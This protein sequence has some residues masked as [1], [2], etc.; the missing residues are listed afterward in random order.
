MTVPPR[1]LLKISNSVHVF[2]Y[3]TTGGRVWN[4]MNALPVMLLTTT[5]RRTGNAHT[6][7]VVFLKDG[8]NYV[9]APGLVESPAW[10]L[11]LK[12]HPLAHIQIGTSSMPVEATVAHGEERQRL[13]A[14]VPTYWEEYQKNARAELPV[15]ILKT[16]DQG[17]K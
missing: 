3:R 10:Y 6:V 15:V 7:P 12:A 14:V 16:L 2:L 8:L 9:I 5:G 17:E 4:R 1:W 13:W 11:N